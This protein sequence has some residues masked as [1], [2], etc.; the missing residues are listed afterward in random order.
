MTIG[1]DHHS[2]VLRAPGGTDPRLAVR[3]VFDE[4][5]ASDPTV[6]D[7][8]KRAH[9]ARRQIEGQRQA[10]AR[11]TKR[12]CVLPADEG[13][14]GYLR[15]I[16]A[17][18][19]MAVNGLTV[20]AQKP[21]RVTAFQYE[22]VRGDVRLTEQPE[23]DVLVLQRPTS[24][25]W[26]KAI[27][28]LQEA[29]VRVVVDIDDDVMSISPKHPAWRETH[30]KYSPNDNRD[31]QLAS[32]RLADQVVVTT[33]GLQER[34]GGVVVPNAIPESYLT[35]Q[36]EPRDGPLWVGWTGAVW[37]HPDDLDVTGGGVAR[38]VE[39][40]GAQF[41]SIGSP[42]GVAKGLRL[43]NEPVDLGSA[44]I[45]GYPKLVAQLD[46]G[47]APLADTEFNSQ[48]CIDA[49][50]RVA[51]SRGYIPIGELTDADQVWNLGEWV[52]VKA[53]ER[54]EPVE[55]VRIE[56]EE[57]HSIALTR[58]HRLWVN[59]DWKL[60]GDIQIGDSVARQPE[61]H[62][63]G[64]YLS[65]P[66]PSESRFSRDRQDD[67][68]KFLDAVDGPKILLNERWG[69]LL[70]LFAGDG[71]FAG[72]TVVHIACDGQD[73]DLIASIMDDWSACGMGARTD[74]KTHFNGEILRRRTVRVSNSNLVR[75]MRSLGVAIMRDNGNPLRKVCVPEAIFRSPKRV[76]AAFLAGL[77][78]ADGSCGRGGVSF[79]SKHHYFAC[80][81]QR[82]LNLFGVESRVRRR[83]VKYQNG[84][85]DASILTIRRA[86]AFPFAEFIGFLSDRK[87]AR[88]EIVVTRQTP[89]SHRR[90]TW[91][92]I[93]EIRRRCAEGERK[94]WIGR[95]FGI[96]GNYVK[97]IADFKVWRTEF[98]YMPP[99]PQKWADVVESIESCVVDPVDIQVVGTVF[100]A[101]GFVSHN[102][103]LKP[104]DFAACG[105]PFVCS[106]SDAY[107]EF[108]AEGV[109]FL[110]RRPNDWQKY[111]RRLL[112]SPSLRAE[113]AEAGRK[114]AAAHTIERNWHRFAAVW[115]GGDA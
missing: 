64:E 87:R 28:A 2:V 49:A 79:T 104:L 14:C 99:K 76:I 94:A 78:E 3:E 75:F 6:S 95:D 114:V 77:F 13:G 101:S 46:V 37:T 11:S 96:D 4:F 41:V 89:P 25:L 112:A 31:H 50:V 51:S 88:L 106:P 68:M 105:V 91:E 86:S 7:E 26:P 24:I 30:P 84:T 47:I 29:G 48:K 102:S 83:K 92:Q 115:L 93:G 72:Q 108:V 44:P 12:I 45:S 66:Y 32:L 38:A 54:Q 40:E 19:M 110:A 10:L 56:T 74:V 8:V 21:G 67:P 15:V 100:A 57:G 113:Q 60:A 69:R 36:R 18:Q 42:K 43:R 61:D 58:N 59:G 22:T 63:D 90:L 52:D 109:G 17:A 35:E 80:D 97:R 107:R 53:T 34:Y 81:V 65:L 70:G 82:L 62:P 5:L 20:T 39:S 98:G 9:L 16:F 55:G 23:F 73:Q 33:P 71:S 85:K 27:V 111:V 103:A 1:P